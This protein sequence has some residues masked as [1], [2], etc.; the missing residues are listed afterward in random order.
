[1]SEELDKIVVKRC[2][3]MLKHLEMDTYPSRFNIENP[4]DAAIL[5][6]ALEATSKALG[7][8]PL[9]PEPK[10]KP[11]RSGRTRMDTLEIDND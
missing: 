7:V 3:R 8:D 4:K 9:P 5:L 11:P 1:M 6:M 10:P 2:K